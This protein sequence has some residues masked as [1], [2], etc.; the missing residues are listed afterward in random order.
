MLTGIVAD[1]RSPAPSCSVF[2]R[3]AASIVAASSASLNVAP[4]GRRP[5]SRRVRSRDSIRPTKP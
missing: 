3:S 1:R 5:S 4:A 2:Q